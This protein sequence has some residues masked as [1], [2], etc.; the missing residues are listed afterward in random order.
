MQ[1]ES[2][3]SS[4]RLLGNLSVSHLFGN[5]KKYQETLG[6]FNELSFDNTLQCTYF[7]LANVFLSQTGNSFRVKMVLYSDSLFHH[8]WDQKKIT[9]RKMKHSCISFYLFLAIEICVKRWLYVLKF[10]YDI[11]VKPGPN[12][13]SSHAFCSC[14]WKLNNITA[15]NHA[16]TYEHVNL[17]LSFLYGIVLF[18]S[19]ISLAP[20]FLWV[21]SL[22]IRQLHIFLTVE[23]NFP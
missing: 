19:W 8:C 20:L 13:N 10:L 23:T 11:K 15:H 3:P 7:P 21:S 18:V 16:R 4:L 5:I 17:F 1:S 22:N 2:L 12:R 14:P 9:S 6:L